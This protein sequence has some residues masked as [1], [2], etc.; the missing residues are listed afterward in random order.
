MPSNKLG[1]TNA[2]KTAP[3]DA[4]EDFVS[5][6]FRYVSKRTMSVLGYMQK[7]K[8][9]APSSPVRQSQPKSKEVAAPSTR[10]SKRPVAKLKKAATPVRR[11][12]QEAPLAVITEVP[13]VVQGVLV[14][15]GNASGA[16]VV[17]NLRT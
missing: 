4:E 11:V 9:S 1:K 2:G 10:A 13:P 3:R 12:S 17:L 6:Q 8:P 5:M 14:R 15:Q 16:G 7:E